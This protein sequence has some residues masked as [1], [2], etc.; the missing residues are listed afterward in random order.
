VTL[1][2]TRKN[3]SRVSTHQLAD[4]DLIEA[5]ISR[6]R[7]EES[8]STHAMTASVNIAEPVHSSTSIS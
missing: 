4:H 1:Y 5:N 8:L 6:R 7:H 3:L 2:R